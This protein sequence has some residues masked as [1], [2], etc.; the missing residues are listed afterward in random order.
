MLRWV[1]TFVQR[2]SLGEQKH[3]RRSATA[4][5]HATAIPVK[6]SNKFQ[7]YNYDEDRAH[8]YNARLQGLNDFDDIMMYP[9][10]STDQLQQL[11]DQHYLKSEKERNEQND[12]QISKRA[13]L[14]ENN[15]IN[16]E[17]NDDISSDYIGQRRSKRN[18]RCLH[19]C[20]KRGLLHP[21][22]CH[23]LC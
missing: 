23:M 10:L 16:E 9:S 18:P 8:E 20:L 14:N 5:S 2:L 11:T 21:A 17:I 3:L 15:D 6:H 7:P 22:Q 4:S 12:L 13:E 1:H 19:T